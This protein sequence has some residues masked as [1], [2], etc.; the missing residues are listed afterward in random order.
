MKKQHILVLLFCLSVVTPQVLFAQAPAITA[1]HVLAFTNA[2]RYRAGLPVLTN[3]QTLSQVAFVKMQDL[4]LR[5]YFAHESPTGES[6][7]DLARNAGYTYLAVGENLALGDFYSNK[8]VVDSWM[9]SPGHR[10]NILSK[11]YSEIGIAAGR[12][13]YN[14]RYTW[15]IVQAFGLPRS[16]CPALNPEAKARIE[17]IEKRLTTLA[18]VIEM[19]KK[20]VEEKGISRTEYVR[21]V[22]L[23]NTVVTLYNKYVKEQKR[24]VETYN[25]DVDSF[26]ECLDEK[27]ATAD[28]SH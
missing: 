12:G 28:S 27:L 20:S 16:S 15:V 13:M 10:A 14:G 23:Y 25:E 4:F 17:A 8:H 6:V 21:R 9:D 5:Q 2:Q 19:R 24:L 7:S 1:Q 11:K 3:N 22:E 26:N 18:T